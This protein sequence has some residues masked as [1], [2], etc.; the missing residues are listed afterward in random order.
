MAEHSSRRV[1]KVASVIKSMETHEICAVHRLK[2]LA[3]FW[4]SSENLTG[5]ERDV[6]EEEDLDWSRFKALAVPQQGGNEH[7]V[8]VMHP[9]KISL[10]RI[11]YDCLRENAVDFTIGLLI[12]GDVLVPLEDFVLVVRLRGRVPHMAS[13]TSTSA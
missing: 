7:E 4:E 8:V 9:H 12:G 11:F 5:R 3:R 10:L 13:T 6:Q 1:E 2:Q